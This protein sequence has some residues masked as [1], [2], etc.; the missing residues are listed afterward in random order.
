MPFMVFKRRTPAPATPDDP[1]HLYLVL[2]QTN[3]GPLAL[4][5]HQG[6][7]L[8][9]WHGQYRNASDVAIELPT[10]AGKTLVGGLIADY[11]RRAAG[12]RVAYLCPTR[13]LARQ[14]AA[15]L[16][17]YGIPTALL[18]GRVASW[19]AADRARYSSADAVAVSVY[20][21]LFNSNPALDNAQMLVLD[22]AHA[23]EGYVAGPW[24]LEI[25]R[26][27]S[28]YT[29]VLST[30]ADA[31]DP[32]VVDRLRTENPDNQYLATVY[33]ASPVGVAAHAAQ[34]EQVLAAAAATKTISEAARHA[35]KLL[36]GRLD[37][38]MVY[39]SYRRLLI[40]PLVP[41]PRCTPRSVIP[42][43]AST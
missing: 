2:A 37:R 29:D 35:M 4:W 41:P 21:H 13:Q 36:A 31:F 34:L 16:D 19:N 3:T 7:V 10:G 28:A 5:L 17:G 15:A 25:T 43:A 23:A 11:Q 22:D 33:L 14:S 9:A 18:I 42:P 12:E 24:S 32:L 1:E 27:E 8:R 30:L 6:D 26:G 20:S 40:R 39:I 38:S